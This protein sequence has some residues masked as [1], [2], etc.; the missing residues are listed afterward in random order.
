[1]LERLKHFFKMRRF[2]NGICLWCKH[3]N[4]CVEENKDE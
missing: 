4:Y 2:C 1:M 3:Y